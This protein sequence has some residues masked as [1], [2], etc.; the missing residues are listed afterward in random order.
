MKVEQRIDR[1]GQRHDT[2]Y[3]SSLCYLGSAEEIVYGRL[4]SRLPKA[5]G[6][7][8][9]QQP[10]LLPVT[11]EE[12]QSLA[13]KTLSEYELARSAEVR[14]RDIQQRT[15]SMAIPAKGRRRRLCGRP[16][17]P[18][19]ERLRR[20]GAGCGRVAREEGRPDHRGDA[21]ATGARART[22]FN[23]PSLNTGPRR[24]AWPSA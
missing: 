7:V 13:A 17:D 24:A 18:T 10:S 1:I 22:H 4:L 19:S 12:F 23:R 21:C 9:A 14:A 15:A 2:I 11:P 3:V 5:G 8:G 20:R 16:E 6:V